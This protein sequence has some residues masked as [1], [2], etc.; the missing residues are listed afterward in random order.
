MLINVLGQHI[1]PKR[2]RQIL[3]E[4]NPGKSSEFKNLIF[5]VAKV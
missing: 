5:L 4:S 1:K 3:T 2:A